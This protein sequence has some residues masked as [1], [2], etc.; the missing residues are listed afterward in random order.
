MDEN[1][2]SLKDVAIKTAKALENALQEKE[3]Q[4]LK[5]EST[6]KMLNK[7]DD[8]LNAIFLEIEADRKNTGVPLDEEY[9]NSYWK[10]KDADEAN[11]NAQTALT[12][13]D[14]NLNADIPDVMIE[15]KEMKA[16][17]PQ[18]IMQCLQEFTKQQFFSNITLSFNNTNDVVD[19]FFPEPVEARYIKFRPKLWTESPTLRCAVYVDNVLQSTPIEKYSATSIYNANW[20]NATMYGNGWCPHHPY[21]TN[22]R[23]E[24]DL[25]ESKT[26]TGIRVGTRKGYPSE[27]VSRLALEFGN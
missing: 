12:K 8:E 7:T 21:T 14:E 26:I 6:Y 23:I 4:K 10:W 16:M 5:L 13:Y 15:L 9:N 27:H 22:E 11:K 25:E 20:H 17:L 24:L 2:Q 18:M 1:Y 19:I 3:A